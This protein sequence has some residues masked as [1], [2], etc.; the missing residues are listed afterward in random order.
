MRRD[1]DAGQC[2]K[3]QL[4]D[5]VAFA[6]HLIGQRRLQ[7]WWPGQPSHAEGLLQSLPQFPALLLNVLSPTGSANPIKSLVH[8]TLEVIISGFAQRR[9]VRG[10]QRPCLRFEI[11]R[12]P[13][14]GAST[15][16]VQGQDH[17]NYDSRHLIS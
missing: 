6:I 17:H 15:S 1:P 12:L 16:T 13:R 5:Q 11:L 2:L 8:A 9:R 14:T 10:P 4:L 3:H 7:V